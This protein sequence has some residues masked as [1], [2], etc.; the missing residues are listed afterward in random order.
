MYIGTNIYS[1]TYLC[2]YKYYH[3][4]YYDYVVCS[5]FYS[6]LWVWVSWIALKQQDASPIT[7]QHKHHINERFLAGNYKVLY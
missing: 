4:Y 5:W 3:Y 7:L 1:H 6:E 2:I